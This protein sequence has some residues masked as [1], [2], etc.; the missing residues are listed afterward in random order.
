MKIKSQRDFASGLMFIAIGAS[1]AVGALGYN[2]GDSAKP[3]PAFFPFGLGVMLAVLGAAVLF[4]ALTIES[5][6][7]DPIG[8]IAWRPLL[9]IVGSV[10]GFGLLLPRLG[11]VVT[12]PLLIVVSAMA[13]DEFHWPSAVLSGA[14]ITALSWAVFIKGLGLTIPLWPVFLG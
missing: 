9:I 10:V 1:F 5:D 6:D 12:L 13:G 14:L 7:G 2:F 4:K 11:M 3:G 8:G